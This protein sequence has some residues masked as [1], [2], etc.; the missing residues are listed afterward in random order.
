MNPAAAFYKIQQ[1]ARCVIL[2][3]GKSKKK[4]YLFI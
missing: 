2:A 4:L 3:S 1:E